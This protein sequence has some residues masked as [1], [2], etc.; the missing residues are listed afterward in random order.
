VETLSCVSHYQFAWHMVYL[1]DEDEQPLL[2]AGMALHLKPPGTITRRR[3]SSILT[4]TIL[5]PT[6][7]EPSMRWARAWISYY[8]LTRNRVPTAGASA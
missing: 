4:P 8:N 5:S 3:I 7:K 2:L 1:Y 6:D